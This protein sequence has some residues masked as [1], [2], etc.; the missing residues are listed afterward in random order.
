MRTLIRLCLLTVLCTCGLASLSAQ[1]LVVKEKPTVP[2]PMEKRAL[3]PREG[4]VIAPN[5]WAIKDGKYSFLPS[6]YMKA[7]SGQKYVPGKWK[8]TKGGWIYR[9]ETW[10]VI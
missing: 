6:R 5:E 2:A 8:R 10:V 4:F 3:P 9:M 7:R 1:Q